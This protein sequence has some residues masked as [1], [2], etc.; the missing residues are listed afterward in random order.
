MNDPNRQGPPDPAS[1]PPP[2]G[3]ISDLHRRLGHPVRHDSSGG[4]AYCVVCMLLWSSHD[5]GWYSTDLVESL[6]A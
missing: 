6:V 1:G 2:F 5:G 4:Q 3:G